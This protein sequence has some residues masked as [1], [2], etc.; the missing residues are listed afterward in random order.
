MT[1]NEKAIVNQKVEQ[2]FEVACDY[3]H[4][5]SDFEYARL[6]SCSAEV[7][8]TSEWYLLRSYSTIVAAIHR[9]TGICYDALR[10]VY[11]Y[12]A[13]SAQHIS[14]FAHDYGATE[15]LTWLSPCQPQGVGHNAPII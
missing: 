15:R 11:G 7:I 10:W 1:S 4:N 13:T 8:I 5:A 12:T 3:Y 14:K 2:A 9:G 6:R